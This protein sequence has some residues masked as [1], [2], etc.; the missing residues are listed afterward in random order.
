MLGCFSVR[1]ALALCREQALI[2]ASRWCALSCRRHH[3]PIP[4]CHILFNGMLPLS[5][6][7]IQAPKVGEHITL[8][9]TKLVD[10]LKR[11]PDEEGAEPPPPADR[12]YWEKRGS[13]LTLQLADDLLNIA[14]EIAPSLEP[15][16]N[17]QRSARCAPLEVHR[18]A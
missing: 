3:E 7:Q 14:R 11:R 17:R 10:E 5:A 16:Y 18:L 9:F 8:I 15:Q 6:L 12:D 2:L 13:K 4:E 1:D